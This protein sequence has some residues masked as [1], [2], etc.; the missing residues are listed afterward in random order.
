MAGFENELFVVFR[1]L[2]LEFKPT[3]DTMSHLAS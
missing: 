2:Y 3:I 1:A